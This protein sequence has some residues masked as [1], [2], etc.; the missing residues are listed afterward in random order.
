MRP[1]LALVLLL[2]SPLA[3]CIG[4]GALVES[5]ASAGGQAD[6][7]GAGSPAAAAWTP[8]SFKHEFPDDRVVSYEERIVVPEGV[9]GT[10]VFRVFE[11]RFGGIRLL[12]GPRELN[13]THT[14]AGGSGVCSHRESGSTVSVQPED[15]RDHCVE[16]I[17][18][19]PAELVLTLTGRGGFTTRTVLTIE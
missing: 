3:G 16:S 6:G 11:E 15:E 17:S 2:L 8:P 4:G 7:R 12:P 18:P 19:P 10:L 5:G 1:A 13:V 9:E 14:Y